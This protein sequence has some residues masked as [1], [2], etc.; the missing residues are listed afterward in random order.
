VPANH[1]AEL[2]L[3]ECLDRMF[4]GSEWVSLVSLEGELREVLDLM[5]VAELLRLVA[6][7]T[8]K[9]AEPR[10]MHVLGRLREWIAQTVHVR[11]GEEVGMEV[12]KAASRP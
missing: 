3:D 12:A 4:E 11:G 6:A 8:P 10:R 7:R 2:V 5:E 9:M 1:P